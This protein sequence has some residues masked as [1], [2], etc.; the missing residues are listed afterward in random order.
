MN[1]S[2][3]LRTKKNQI[4]SHSQ[5]F[6]SLFHPSS[7]AYQQLTHRIT[8]TVRSTGK[9]P[10]LREPLTGESRRQ[11]GPVILL[12]GR[13]LTEVE[14][15]VFFPSVVKSPPV[16][17]HRPLQNGFMIL[18]E[19]GGESNVKARMPS[20]G[21][22]ALS[23]EERSGTPRRSP[24]M[25]L[26]GSFAHEQSP[27]KIKFVKEEAPVREAKLT[28]I[29]S[30][31]RPSGTEE[32]RKKDAVVE[33]PMHFGV[34][35]DLGNV[36]LISASGYIRCKEHLTKSKLV[37]MDS[38]KGSNVSPTGRSNNRLSIDIY[39]PRVDNTSTSEIESE[40]SESVDV[41]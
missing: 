40:I 33:K 8:P 25:L 24:S 12:D 39:L 7:E 28:A 35:K 2:P 32:S 17:H 11:K 3:L 19:L 22:N 29:P 14:N 34:V 20:L 6:R 5:T 15:P 37:N 26:R 9:N 30:H 21:R 10:G 23:P 27:S 41:N 1:V 18:R 16:V 4:E 36:G 31:Q 38:T 13:A